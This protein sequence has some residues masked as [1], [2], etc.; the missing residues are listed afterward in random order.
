MLD[1]KNLPAWALRPA[2][3]EDQCLVKDA[4]RQGRVQIKWPDIKALRIWTK[5][6]GWPTPIFD[7][8][9]AFVAKMLE[10]KEGFALAV[11]TSGIEV[12]VLRQE[13]TISNE[14]VH[15][16][17]AL[18]GERSSSGI[19]SSWG[20]LVEELRRIRR[21]VEAGVVVT[22]DGGPQILNWQ[23]FY[24]WAHGRYHMLEEGQDKWIGD[25]S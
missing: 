20:I 17:D 22:I 10:T 19:P 2:K 15:E 7:F 13:Y 14:L 8:E 18:Y 3:S 23:D 25:D 4:H 11:E 21:A 6:Q 1:V 5:Q 12:Q 24:S 9:K 16:L